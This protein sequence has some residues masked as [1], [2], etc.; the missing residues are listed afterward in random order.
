MESILKHK[1]QRT[2]YKKARRDI[3]RIAGRDAVLLSG[4]IAAT[5]PRFQVKRN[6]RTSKSIFDDCLN[7][8]A[9]FAIYACT[10]KAQFLK[11]YKLLPAHYNNV[12]I[13]LLSYIRKD[14]K[15]NLSGMK[16]NAFFHNLIGDYDYITIDVWMARFFGHK[17]AQV[18]IGEYRYYCGCLRSINRHVRKR[19]NL[20]LS[21][22]ALQAIIWEYQRTKAGL[23]YSNFSKHI[24]GEP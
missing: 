10:N 24:N 8:P 17:R 4:L 7:D 18:N 12:I 22:A 19:Y 15:Y 14:K 16:V 3:R 5:S 2:W 6:W 13:C 9:S 23:K 11:D 1:A 21:N 20:K